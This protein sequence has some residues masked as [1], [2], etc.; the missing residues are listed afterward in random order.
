MKGAVRMN[1]FY[2]KRF[3]RREDG[4]IY[5]ENAE[6][7]FQYVEKMADRLYACRDGETLLSVKRIS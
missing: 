2:L 4:S 6:S 5:L 3:K 7:V 1:K